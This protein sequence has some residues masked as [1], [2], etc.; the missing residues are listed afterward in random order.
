MQYNPETKANVLA[1]YR[2]GLSSYAIERLLGVPTYRT[3][4][5]WAQEAGIA[6]RKV[7]ISA[8][9]KRRVVALY[10]SGMDW[11]DIK[12][13]L[14]LAVS[15]SAIGSWVRKGGGVRKP[16]QSGEKAHNWQGGVNA[17]VDAIRNSQEY[18]AWRTS[19]YERDN[20]TCLCCDEVG[21][22]LHAHHILA[23]SKYP[24]LRFDIDNGSTLCKKC[25]IKLH[26][27]KKSEAA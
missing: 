22:R 19:V 12:R 7:K 25:H 26:K 15:R 8:I 16:N 24:A 11:R 13:E 14:N 1:L 27:K 23:F 17:V 9:T 21:G 18:L 4:H 2:Q 3:V 5:Q 6:R 20:F 10:D